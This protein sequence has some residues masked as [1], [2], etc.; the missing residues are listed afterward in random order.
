[1]PTLALSNSVAYTALDKAGLDTIRTFP[2]HTYFR[3]NRIHLLHVGGVDLLGLQNNYGQFFACAILD[4]VWRIC[5]DP[6]GMPRQQGR[7]CQIIGRGTGLTR[8]YAIQA[9]ENGCFL[10]F[11]HAAG[12]FLADYQRICQSLHQQF[13]QYSRNMPALSECNMPTS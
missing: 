3:H 10:H 13:R 8:L 9:E 12:R 6:A 11:L 7:Q 5:A 4:N 1:M 2:S